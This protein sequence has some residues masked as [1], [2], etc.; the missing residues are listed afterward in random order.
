MKHSEPIKRTTR[1]ANLTPARAHDAAR[2]RLRK[3]AAELQAMVAKL[4]AEAELSNAEADY[5]DAGTLAHYASEVEKLAGEMVGRTGDFLVFQRGFPI[6]AHPTEAEAL[7]R[8]EELRAA[9]AINVACG[10]RTF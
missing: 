9:G 1:P 5:G 2:T 7:A 10:E 4:D 6:E 3:A 8:V